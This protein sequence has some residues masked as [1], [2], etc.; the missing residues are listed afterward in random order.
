M[1]IS[2]ERVKFAVLGA[3][4]IGKRHAEMISRDPEAE[5]VAMVDIRSAEACGID[6]EIPFFNS[7][8]GCLCCK[9][10]GEKNVG[11]RQAYSRHS[12]ADYGSYF[13]RRCL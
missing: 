10:N 8:D 12:S 13:Q 2:N 9:A 7:I 6:K 4:H 11:S 5:L 1:I 3:G